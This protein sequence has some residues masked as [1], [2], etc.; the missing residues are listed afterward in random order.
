MTG[1][2]FF[3]VEIH[4]PGISC[5]GDPE[6]GGRVYADGKKEPLATL[7]PFEL[8]GSRDGYRAYG[9]YDM[10]LHF[11]DCVRRGRQPEANLDDA[12]KTMELVDAIYR[13]QI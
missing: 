9:P 8:S 13:A 3:T 2:R 12:V 1:R 6:E 7:D 4:A 10:N 5:F 11:I